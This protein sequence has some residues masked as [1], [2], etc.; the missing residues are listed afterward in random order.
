MVVTS[1]RLIVAL[2]LTIL[3]SS[4]NFQC[5][6]IVVSRKGYIVFLDPTI[7]PSNTRFV[8]LSILKKVLQNIKPEDSLMYTY[9]NVIFGF[10]ARLSELE[11]KK[12]ASIKGVLSVM[13]DQELHIHP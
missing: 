2:A 12:L 4:F 6:A 10:A 9:R 1:P 11:A 5:Q 3:M 13:P 8:D 7:V